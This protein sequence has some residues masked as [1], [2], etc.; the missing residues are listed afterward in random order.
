MQKVTKELLAA[1]EK[2][3]V[4]Y[5][6]IDYANAHSWDITKT[7]TLINLIKVR[8]V[9][10][11]QSLGKSMQSKLKSGKNLFDVWMREESDTIQAVARAYGERMCLEKTLEAGEKCGD[12]G[13][14]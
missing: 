8:E 13:V 12:A 7:S 9:I 2:G 11:L 5:P 4:K 14:K 3:Q 6:Q 10:L 1:Y